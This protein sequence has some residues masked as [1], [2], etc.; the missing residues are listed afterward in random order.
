MKL[1]WLIPSTFGT[2]FML[3]S[4]ALAGKLESWRFDPN[5]NRLEFNTSSAVQPQAQLIFDPTRLVIDLPGT[6]FGR[7][8]LIQQIGGQ[9][10]AIRIGQF[11]AQTTRLVVELAP[12]YTFNSSLIKFVPIN[13]SRWIVELPNPEVISGQN[14]EP[15]TPP[16]LDQSS[17]RTPSDNSIYNVV[18]TN[19]VTPSKQV[20]QI[21]RLQVTGDGFFV[22]V[23]ANSPWLSGNNQLQV[24]PSLDNRS[25][26]I[27]ILGAVLSPNMGQRDL[28]I[29]RYGVRRIQFSQLPSSPSVVRMTLYLDNSSRSWRAMASGNSGFIVIPD[30]IPKL[31]NNYQSSTPS[32]SDS[33]ATIQSVEIGAGRQLLIRADQAISATSNWDRSSGLF[34]ITIPNSKLANQVQSPTFN[35]NSPILKVRFQSPAAN[36]VVVLVQPAAGVSFGVL[37]QVPSSVLAL[38]LQTTL[39]PQVPEIT[40]PVAPIDTPDLLTESSPTVKTPVEEPPLPVPKEKILVVIDP[41]HGGKDSG[42]PGL[43]GLLEKDVVLPISTK[44]ARILEQNGVQVVLTRDADFF[45]ELQGRVDIAKRV[46]ATVFVSIHANSVDNRPE[47]NGLEVYY[48]DSGYGLAETVRQTILQNISTLNNRGTRKARFYVLRKN[49]MPAILVETGYMTGREDNPRLGSSDYQSRMAEGIARGVLNY[50]KRR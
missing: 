4:P 37:N 13:G 42:A 32:V 35:R 49:S 38:P 44:L 8:Q 17:Q 48:Y 27:D 15:S 9:I 41:G 20:T 46:N 26:N 14:R 18:T 11:D 24:N 50:L 12:G 22:G 1:H 45:V 39:H 25:V 47:V 7:P 2:V 21:E 33:L 34:R 36:T 43:G 10:R 5:Q 29:N 19:P 16:P 6:E 30:R 40:P 28:L 23:A 3:S 31:S